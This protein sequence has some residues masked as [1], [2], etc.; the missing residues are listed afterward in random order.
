MVLSKL[1]KP[2]KDASAGALKKLIGRASSGE[3][4]EAAGRDQDTV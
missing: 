1:N 4:K 2:R 3:K